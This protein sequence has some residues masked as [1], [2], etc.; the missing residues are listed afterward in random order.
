MK[1]PFVCPKCGAQTPFAEFKKQFFVCPACAYH[2]RL[3]WQNRLEISSD[4]GSFLEL[5]K[6]LSSANPLG[7]P[8]YEEKIA[9]IK[10]EC[11][12][13]EAVITGRCTLKG[14]PLVLGIMDSRFMM[15]SMG[16]A[17]GEKI[18]RAFEYA[19]KN[20]LPLVMF[21]ASG[22]ARM[23]E[24][25]FSLMQMAKTAGAAGR[26]SKAGLLYISVITDPTTGG[27]TASFAS[28]GDIIIAEPGTLIGF[29]GKRVIKDTIGHGGIMPD[30]FQSSEFAL[31]CGFADMIIHRSKLKENIAA[32]LRLH[33]CK[34]GAGA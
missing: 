7:F 25:I 10:K 24:G 18:T 8:G 16:S 31:R 32:I 26:H 2:S 9:A 34:K 4:P 11:E 27:V 3:S 20:K 14:F 30:D 22:G 19:E 21:T 5:D 12:T 15:G 17:A 28:L 6:S 29:A 33:G 23:Q 13:N 1:A